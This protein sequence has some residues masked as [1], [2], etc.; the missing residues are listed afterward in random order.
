MLVFLY[1]VSISFYLCLSYDII[2]ITNFEK[3]FVILTKD[4]NYKIFS[5][6]H[7]GPENNH[8]FIH[9][10][11]AY[12][13]KQTSIIYMV[14]I[15]DN[16]SLI[17][18]SESGK[19]INS[20]SLVYLREKDDY[21]DFQDI[22]NLTK[23]YYFVI[24]LY[25]MK[26][27]QL[28]ITFSIYSTDTLANVSNNIQANFISD[29]Y[30][31]YYSS[32][33][34]QYK[35]QIPKLHKK[36]L[37]FYHYFQGSG[38]KFDFLLYENG[39]KLVYNNT[40]KKIE[41]YIE[42]KKDCFYI[43]NFNF[44]LYYL[45]SNSV[46]FHLAQ[47][48]YKTNIPAEFGTEYFERYPFYKET[49]FLL[50][51]S[52]VKKGNKM[53]IE[54]YN[55]FE[56]SDYY[57][58]ISAYRYDTEDEN[59]IE[60]TEGEKIEFLEEQEKVGDEEEDEKEKYCY[61]NIC[62][63]FILKDSNDMKLLIFKIKAKN[64]YYPNDYCLD[65]RYGTEEKYAP[66]K[67]YLSCAIGLALSIP[68]IIAQ[69]IRCCKGIKSPTPLTLIMDIILH[70]VYINIIAKFVYIGRDSSFWLGIGLGAIYLLFSLYNYYNMCENE[71][72][73]FTG[74]KCLLK[75]SKNLRTIEEAIN[76]RRKLPPQLIIGGYASKTKD[77]IDEK[78][79][80]EFRQI[81]YEYC[82]WEDI[83]DFTFDK[84]YPIIECK[85]ELELTYDKEI[86]EDIESIK[87]ELVDSY[88]SNYCNNFKENETCFL[89]HY[90]PSLYKFFIFLWFIF[91]ITGYLDIFEI[92]IYYE[93]DKPI[94]IKIKKIISS[95]NN[96]RAC[97]NQLDEKIP[98]LSTFN[99]NEN[100]AHSYDTI[101]LK[102]EKFLS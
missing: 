87:G 60:N 82:S 5:Y 25:E 94:T 62:K 77:T 15:Y 67:I 37:Y 70:L 96:L 20:S 7:Q 59:I 17:S 65:F 99:K 27:T 66:K 45:D 26:D 9:R 47:S 64:N 90:N 30:T 21:Y 101:E 48:A 16:I 56:K 28:N 68:N 76:E 10:I 2:S 44:K 35:F 1:I 80:K 3:K 40:L 84:K 29:R 55:I 95:A 73:I 11:R 33:I 69:I 86:E 81:E 13:H 58:Y 36:Y 85:F 75:K 83:T 24:Q 32:Y 53:M 98:N 18:Q 49:N 102:S 19:F 14:Y 43:I 89:E 63:E 92:F 78:E 23:I 46:F 50:N 57:Y 12:Y 79:E 72:T 61:N 4:K 74:Y 34:R 38:I 54:Y 88:Q 6:I 93:T 91:Y 51:V 42:L 52:T 39:E 100:I 97:H 41:S 8:T 71:K 22:H 31:Y